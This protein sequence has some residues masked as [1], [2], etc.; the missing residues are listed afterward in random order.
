MTAVT[1]RT[2]KPATDAQVQTA[3]NL[4]RE[5]MAHVPE[6]LAVSDEMEAY[7]RSLSREALSDHIGKAI[8]RAALP[9][10][11]RLRVAAEYVAAWENHNV[12]YVIVKTDNQ[13]RGEDAVETVFGPYQRYTDALDTCQQMRA[14]LPP[15]YATHEDNPI[16]F[17][18]FPIVAG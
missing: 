8:R 2:P 5:A 12:M 1:A 13:H 6:A 9:L 18:V 11:P 14:M 10:P 15:E 4:Y 3:M 17:G 16:D 7:F